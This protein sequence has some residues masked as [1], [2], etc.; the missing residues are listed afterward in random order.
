MSNFYNVGILG[1]T[2]IVGQK[3]ISLLIDHP[4]FRIHSISASS[5]N[6]GKKYSS[7]CPINSSDVGNLILKPAIPT[8][9]G[10]CHFIF[11]CLHSNLS[12]EIEKKFLEYDFLIFSNCYNYRLH[13]LVPLVVPTV[14]SY[15]LDTFR[16]KDGLNIITNANCSTT[17]IVTVL[18]PLDLQFGIKRVS[19]TTLQSISGAGKYFDECVTGNIIPFIKSEEEKIASETL[20]IL[21]KNIDN[22]KI[23]ATCN[24]VPV[25]NG[26][27]VCMSIE[28]EYIPTISEIIECLQ[29]YDSYLCD[30]VLN[31]P[32]GFD[33]TFIRIL[34]QDDRPQPLLDVDKSNGFC[35]SVGRIR[36][37]NVFHIK[38]TIHFN[39][40][41]LGAAGS[42]LLNAEL[43]FKNNARIS[44]EKT[45]P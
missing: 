27:T 21:E 22:F 31:T 42:T 1:G 26:H 5:K 4:F 6:V 37:C 36:K 24:R 41:V 11:S 14:N 35:V 19:V 16:A 38:L 10:D 40:I 28:F 33:K 34:L 12:S 39:N 23:S 29:S 25:Q 7:V 2:G 20:K 9:F 13:P 45:Q 15:I 32:T 43:Y 17:G 3:L 18:Y 8:Y 30:N 44:N